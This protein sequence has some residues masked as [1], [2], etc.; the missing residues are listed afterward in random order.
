ML[1]CNGALEVEYR[2]IVACRNQSFYTIKNGEISG[3]VIDLDVQP[4]GLVIASKCWLFF[5]LCLIYADIFVGCMNNVIHAF[6]MRGKK[7][8]THYLPAAITRYKRLL[9]L[10]NCYSMELLCHQISNSK[11]LLVALANCEVRVYSELTK[12]LLSTVTLESPVTAM[13]FGK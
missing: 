2:V 3:I 9:C 11:A 10:N 7:S 6:Q 1:N 13:R 12:A 8:Y 4:V 5:C